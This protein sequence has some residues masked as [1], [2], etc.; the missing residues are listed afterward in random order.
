MLIRNRL[1]LIFTLLATA[2]QLT[3]SGIILYFNAHFRQDEFYERLNEKAQ[4]AGRIL[5]AHRHLHD[6]FFRNMLRTDLLTIVDEQISIFD[7]EGRLVFSNRPLAD[8]AYLQAQIPLLAAGQAVEFES[9]GLETV[10]VPY[11]DRGQRFY[12]FT[13]GRDRLGLAKLGTLQQILVLANLVGFSLIVLAGWYFSSK[14]LQPISLIVEQ[15]EQITASD[16]HLRLAEGNRQDEIAQLAMTFNDMLLRLENAFAS[17]RSFVAHASHELRT[18]LTNI[19]GTLE[20]SL[21]YDTDMAA[22]QESMAVAMEEIKHV[23]GLTNSLLSLAKVGDA[24]V[25]FATLQADDVLLTAVAQV[26]A[27]Y[28][29]RRFAIELGGSEQAEADFTVRGHQALL[30]TAFTNVL[31]NA[32]KYSYEPVAVHLVELPDA[33][34]LTVTDR[35]RGIEPQDLAHVRDPLYRGNN[36]E[37]VPG[38]G[39]GLAV[40]EKIVALHGGTMALAS[41][42]GHGTTVTLRIPRPEVAPGLFGATA[43]A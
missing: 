11:P 21:R 20:T 6:D 31:D 18:P 9:K 37:G 28:P 34:K 24:A 36:T 19:L 40:T 35:G 27:K 13:S 7:E 25:A 4:I 39:I 42:V 14:V 32:C 5:I 2:I 12:I 16:L 1:T 15:V 3:L 30:A 8:S 43:A 38:F 41:T 29:G 33:L 23:I 26:Q 17:Q 10:V 22:Y